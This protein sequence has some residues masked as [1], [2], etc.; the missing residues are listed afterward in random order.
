MNG[1]I[2]SIH[3]SDESFSML[4]KLRETERELSSKM[5]A[6]KIVSRLVKQEYERTEKEKRSDIGCKRHRSV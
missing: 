1:K 6:S 4:E 3:F 2:C 5:S